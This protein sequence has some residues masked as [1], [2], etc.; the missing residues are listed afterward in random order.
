MLK[1]GES[2]VALDAP[3]RARNSQ[4]TVEFGAGGA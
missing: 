1:N 2:N 4:A 3:S